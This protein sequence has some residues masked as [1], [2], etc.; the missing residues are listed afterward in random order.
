MHA[1]AG[2]GASR[3][4]KSWV[5]LELWLQVAHNDRCGN[6][7]LPLKEQHA[8]VNAEQSVQHPLLY[9]LLFC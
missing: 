4:Q 8:L 6:Q 3:G 2:T 1:R 7:S 5:T 9:V